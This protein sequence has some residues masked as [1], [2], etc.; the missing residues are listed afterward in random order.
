MFLLVQ[1]HCMFCEHNHS[2]PNTLSLI[3]SFSVLDKIL[4]VFVNK[5]VLLVVVTNLYY[6]TI[7]NFFEP[8]N[9]II[10]NIEAH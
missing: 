5:R 8:K 4:K 7:S 2:I 6:E 9:A 3:V 1:N 10:V